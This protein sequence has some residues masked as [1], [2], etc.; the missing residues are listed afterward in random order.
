MQ[1]GA[2]KVYFQIAECSLSYAKITQTSAMKVYFQ[3][4]ECS[5]SYAK[6][7]QTSAMKVYF[8]IAE[9]SLS[10]A[11]IL[12]FPFSQRLYCRQNAPKRAC[13]YINNV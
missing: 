9:C 3:I 12:I 11:K 5:L 10:Y 13:N 7:M 6:I 2:M 8:Q 4:A 1:T